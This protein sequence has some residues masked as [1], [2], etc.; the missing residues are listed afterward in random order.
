MGIRVL[1]PVSLDGGPQLSRRDRIVLSALVLERPKAVSRDRLE[2]LVWPD[3]A[4]A[5]S[6]KVIQGC[7]ARLRGRLD[8]RWIMTTDHGYRLEQTGDLDMTAF[9]RGVARGR[10]LLQMD[11]PDR[12]KHVL[13]D[14][15][16]LWRGVPFE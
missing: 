7:V 13:G 6:T 3:G 2:L 8:Q 10:E 4:P 16:A 9:E 1:G 12:A 11:Q 15:L 5:T 14:A